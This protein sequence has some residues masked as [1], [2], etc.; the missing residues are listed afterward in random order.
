M[1]RRVLIILLAVPIFVLVISFVQLLFQERPF[2]W[3][4]KYAVSGKDPYAVAVLFDQLPA[5]FR[6]KEIRAL[7]SVD[8]K[9]YQQHLYSSIEDSS[10]YR[11]TVVDSIIQDGE[12]VETYAYEVDTAQIFKGFSEDKKRDFNLFGISEYLS[13]GNSASWSILLHVYQGNS[14]LL[15]AQTINSDLTEL[16]DIRIETLDPDSLT[17]SQKT[18]KYALEFKDE[19]T[20]RY[21]PYERFSRIIEY[22]EGS[23]IIARNEDG[24]IIGVKVR[25]GKG[26]VTF[27]TMPILFTNYYLLKERNAAVESLLLDLPEKDTYWTNYFVGRRYYS[28][29]KPSLLSFIHSK[30]S[31]KWAFYTLLFSVLAFLAFEL[32]RKQ[33]PIPV[34]EPPENT[35]LKF[36]ATISSLYMMRKDHRDMALRKMNFFLMWVRDHYYLDTSTLSESFYKKLASK[37]DLDVEFVRQ[38]FIKYHYI[39][40]R[41]SI[42]P[43]EF[44][45]FGLLLQNFKNNQNG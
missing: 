44:T 25:V 12:S 30:P 11:P 20:V 26:S 7:N 28:G 6:N 34:V 45:E 18:L 39:K 42:T 14:A 16:L 10:I 35:S 4:K 3:D 32:R 2:D 41:H 1:K 33:R 38:L 22:P 27:F 40:A 15:C 9:P 31:L 36:A 13:I 29:P 37:S 5:F 21:K 17:D 23:E 24:D 19:E 43:E 8:L